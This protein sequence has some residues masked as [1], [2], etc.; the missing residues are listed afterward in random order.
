MRRARRIRRALLLTGAFTLATAMT[1]SSFVE[2]APALEIQSAKPGTLSMEQWQPWRDRFV[3][4]DGRVV[5]DVN[6]ISHSEG[7]GRS[8]DGARP[9]RW[10][11]LFMICS[12]PDGRRR[13]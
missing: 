7:Q 4:D 8:T 2:A 10:V 9:R 1:F 6:Q 12:R 13:P 11:N 5:D 3:G